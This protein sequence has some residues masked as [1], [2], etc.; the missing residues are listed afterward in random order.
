MHMANDHSQWVGHSFL[1]FPPPPPC[2]RVIF[3][4]FSQCTHWPFGQHILQ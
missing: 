1:S 3:M 2:W 4:T